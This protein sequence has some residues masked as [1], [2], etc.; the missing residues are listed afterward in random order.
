M[1]L[2]IFGGSFDP[3]HV[4]HLLVAVDSYEQLGLDRLVFVPAAMQPLK[5]NRSAASPAD[6]LELVRLLVGQDPRFEVDPV[7]I[8][9]RGLSYTVDTLETYAR[10]FPD[11][12]R[13][14]LIG[15]DALETFGAWR[16]PDRILGLAGLVVL[17]RPGS[18]PG[19]ATVP[20]GA[21]TLVTRLVDVSSTEVRERIRAGKSIRGFVP[22]SVAE[23][24]DSK[25]LYR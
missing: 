5:V 25:R 12:E 14:F 20:R 16:E 7:E 1:R 19:A 21:R 9:R 10:R 13:F 11:A 24:I 23:F 4:G 6:R 17:R 18:P 2:G 3:P 15:S 8:E 22:E